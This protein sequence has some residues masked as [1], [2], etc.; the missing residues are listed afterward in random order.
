LLWGCY[1]RLHSP[2][3]IINCVEWY[4]S[5]ADGISPMGRGRDISHIDYL[6]KTSTASDGSTPHDRFIISHVTHCKRMSLPN[7]S[8]TKQA[9]THNTQQKQSIHG[10]SPCLHT[11]RYVTRPRRRSSADRHGHGPR[12][13]AQDATQWGLL[14]GCCLR[15]L[16]PDE[17]YDIINCVEWYLSPMQMVSLLWG[18]RDS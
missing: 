8:I 5:Y 17:S 13:S 2:Y 10:K 18:G 12:D 16:S 1:L 14:S 11:R 15:L 3:D 6:R 4:L 9:S 7:K